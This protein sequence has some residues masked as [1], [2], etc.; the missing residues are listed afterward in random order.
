[1]QMKWLKQTMGR[2]EDWTITFADILYQSLHMEV[3]QGY[4]Q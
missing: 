3:S 1:M 2:G 4:V